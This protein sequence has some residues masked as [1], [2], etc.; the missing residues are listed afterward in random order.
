[1]SG[2]NRGVNDLA[3]L[4]PDLA[5]QWDKDRNGGMLPSDV[6]C[7]SEKK[8]WWKCSLG[9]S[10]KTVVYSRTEGRGCPVCAKLN[11]GLKPGVNDLATNGPRI[12]LEEWDA[13]AN[14]PFTPEMVAVYSN[15]KVSWKCDEGHRW[16]ATV[17]HRL[18]G[19]RCPYCSNKVVLRGYND[20]KTTHPDIASEWDDE[21]NKGLY[22]TDVTAGADKKV[23]WKCWKGHSWYAYIY[24]RKAGTGCPFCEGVQVIT[25]ETD[26][27]TVRP[28]IASEWDYEKNFPLTPSEIAAYSGKKPGWICKEGH[29]WDAVVSSRTLGNSGCPYCSGR[30]VL[31]GYNDLKSQNPDLASEWHPEKNGELRPEHIYKSTHKKVWWKCENG[32]SF[33]AAVSWR[34]SGTECPYCK[35][36]AL[37]QGFND[38]AT[39]CPELCSEWDTEKNKIMPHEINR[40]S[41]E[42]V[43]WKCD[44]GHEWQ[45]AVA[46]RAK[47]NGCPY[48]GNRVP[49][50][51][52]NDFYT[53]NPELMKEWNSEKNA[54]VDPHRLTYQ[55]TI[56]VW[57][58]CKK[59]HEWQAPIYSRRKGCGCPICA[60]DI[61]RHSVIKGRNDL[62]S[63]FPELVASWDDERNGVLKPDSIMTHSNRKIWWKCKNGHHWRATVLGRA[64]G[65]G[66]P[67]CEG[68]RP[69]LS[70]FI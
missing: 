67:I 30:K 4:R 61:N 6:T 13:E 49:V 19:D 63:R 54:G 18:R 39:Q 55:S 33:R 28:D 7:G 34:A 9:H 65:T 37:L 58:K 3:T 56:S 22:P 36:K 23:W 35:G 16:K 17:N 48:C 42:K 31:E 11:T 14:F 20:L 62:Q 51:G 41:K 32:H 47:G 26:L 69:V 57:W 60:K 53:M 1:M 15:R 10:W 38:F 29:S 21:K 64:Y 50:E 52:E 59:G 70:R 44:K 2:L 46:D 27:A 5:A 68:K 40:W 25:G 24:S 66:C 43:W 8:I 45:T 12:L